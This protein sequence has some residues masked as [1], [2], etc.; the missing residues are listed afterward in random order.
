MNIEWNDE[1]INTEGKEEE[2]QYLVLHYVSVC[3]C[4]YPYGHVF[5]MEV[6]NQTFEY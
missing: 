2:V 1:Y 4:E 6:D 5:P 3:C